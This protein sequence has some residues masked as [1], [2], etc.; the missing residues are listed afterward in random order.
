MSETRWLLLVLLLVG[1]VADSPVKVAIT[2]GEWSDDL[3]TTV[4][5]YGE[6]GMGELPVEAKAL[7]AVDGCGYVVTSVERIAVNDRVGASHVAMYEV[8]MT[9]RAPSPQGD[10]EP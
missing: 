8:R 6:A 10:T 2:C 4:E 1:C 5:H 7:R 3:T 9:R